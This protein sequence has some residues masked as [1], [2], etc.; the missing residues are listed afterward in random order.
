MEQQMDD[1]NSQMKEKVDFFA[2]FYRENYTRVFNF[3][4]RTQARKDA[5]AVEDIT[6]STFFE[7][8]RKIDILLSH[9]NQTGWLMETARR[10][11][12]SQLKKC[13]SKEIG[14]DDCQEEPY[15]ESEYNVLELQMMIDESLNAEEKKLF[16]KYFIEKNS[17]KIM[18]Q[19]ENMSEGAFKV[20]MHR[21]RKKVQEHFKEF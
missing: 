20:K 2:K 5:M 21:I 10:K 16:T 3:V 14:Y 12:W 8:W 1:N 17:A 11:A 13:S 19:Q 4:Y 9:P 6:Q 15:V 7:A 18:A